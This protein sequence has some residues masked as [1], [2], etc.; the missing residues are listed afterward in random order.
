[1]Y[2][3]LSSPPVS[4]LVIWN[5]VMAKMKEVTPVY[6]TIITLKVEKTFSVYLKIYCEQKLYKQWSDL[7]KCYTYDV[8]F[9]LLKIYLKISWWYFTTLIKCCN[10]KC[11]PPDSSLTPSKIVSNSW[12]Q[13]RSWARICF[14]KP[15]I[16]LFII[17]F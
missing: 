11:F 17:I 12:P 16:L 15:T 13:Y 9:T 7:R 4:G 3:I 14:K 6:T 10:V 5:P 8:T 1:M 2:L